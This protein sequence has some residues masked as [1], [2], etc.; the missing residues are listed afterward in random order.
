MTRWSS[1]LLIVGS[2][3]LGGCFC[4][5]DFGLPYSVPGFDANFRSGIG[6][7]IVN[8]V[9]ANA[10]L[11]KYEANLDRSG[12]TTVLFDVANNLTT[13]LNKL[14]GH[15]AAT[16]GANSSESLQ[17]LLEELQATVPPTTSALEQVSSTV[18]K[19]KG[20]VR[21]NVLDT[22]SSNVSTIT[23]EIGTLAR[24]WPP[25][26]EVLKEASA[27]GS[28]YSSGNI[29][30]LITPA[31][32]QSI[33]SPVSLI[34]SALSDIA[35]MYGTIAKDRITG[36]GYETTTNSSIQ[37]ALQDLLGSVT[38][39]NRTFM[40]TAR[41]MEQQSNGTVRQVR[42]GY[43]YL[44]T[45]LGDVSTEASKV[46][47]FL[48]RTESQG[49]EHNTRTGELLRDL[50]TNYKRIIQTAGEAIGNRLFNATAS[51]ID[52]AATSDNS[53]ADRCLQRYVGDFRQGSYA[54]TRLSVCYQVDSRT[55]GYLS[56][57]N[58]AFL[59]QLRYS[60]IYGNQAQSVC[61]QGSSNCTTEYLDQL[62]GFTKQTQAR[63]NAFVTFLGEEIMALVE[64][65]DVCTR[66]IRA[67]IEHLVETTQYKFRNCFLTGR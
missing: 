37:N 26:A 25:F 18:H 1:S 13:P 29:S 27:P 14:L 43:S 44:L 49:L 65:Y 58:N 32:V 47:A 22:L 53:Y 23:T 45:R 35:T 41:Q 5:G 17:A 8:I 15:V 4:A 36:I 50:A 30:T 66:A 67:D 11:L 52:E 54:S 62:E 12:A 24:N 64:R 34:N 38:L 6:S 61:G 16:F 31:L 59:E 7:G 9:K 42:D 19:L 60:G 28:T 39:A 21:P 48:D 33:I 3:L 10:S 57:A 51:L 63:L 55:V 2:V 40:D 56:S 46:K 20:A